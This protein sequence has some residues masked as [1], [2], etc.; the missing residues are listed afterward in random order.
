MVAQEMSRFSRQFKDSLGFR[1]WG[2]GDPSYRRIK[3][4]VENR[5]V[6]AFCNTAFK[7]TQTISIL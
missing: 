1:V 2:L 7:N 4:Y 3:N 5:G 6:G